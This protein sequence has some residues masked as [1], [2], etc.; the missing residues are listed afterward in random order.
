M[1]WATRQ[2]RA[3]SH[4]KTAEDK[5]NGLSLAQAIAASSPVIRQLRKAGVKSI[6]GARNLNQLLM[7]LR[8]TGGIDYLTRFI[9]NASNSFN[10]FDDLGH[11]LLTQ[12]Q[13]TNCVDYVTRPAVGCD[14][15]WVGP[16]TSSALDLGAIDKKDV[17]DGVD[18]RALERSD[19]AAN[20]TKD[21]VNFLIG[22][23]N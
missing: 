17:A 12:I 13:I 2:P 23:G 9:L 4:V 18:E 22:S 21:L 15:R 8:R 16:G 11:F 19:A 6:P 14:G 5:P 3:V 1:R 7:T 20:G 10:G